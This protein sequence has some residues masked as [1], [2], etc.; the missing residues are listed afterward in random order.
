MDFDLDAYLAPFDPEVMRYPEGRKA[1]TRMEPLA[2]ALTYL[3]PHLRDE[4]TG[5][6]TLSEFHLDLVQHA[7]GWVAPEREPRQHRDCFVAPRNAGKSSWCF[8]LLPLWAAC[9]GHKEFIAAI[10][11]SATQSEMHLATLRR[12][13]ETNTLLR[14]DFPEV[15][16]PARKSR[17]TAES[18]NVAM[19]RAASGFTI[20]A[21]G[22]DSRILGMKVGNKRPDL[23]LMDDV[24][25]PEEN[26]SIALKDKRL[27]AIQDSILPLNERARVV[28]VGTVT[29]PDSIIHD[30]VKS[31][32]MPAEAPE[33]IA[34]Q[35]FKT[36][37]YPALITDEVTGEERSV[38]PAKWSLEYLR[39]IRHTRDFAKNFMNDPRGSGGAWWRPEDFTYGEVRGL[40]RQVLSIDPA[41]TASGKSD[42]TALSVVAYSPVE[43]KCVVLDAWQLRIQPGKALRDRVL[44]ILEEYLDT[45]GV[46]VESNQGGQVWRSILHDISVPIT[47]IHQSVAKEVRAANL[48]N[49]YQLGKVVHAKALTAA[50]NQ[51]IAFPKAPHDDLI[52]SIGAGVFALLPKPKKRGSGVHSVAVR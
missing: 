40:A 15:C 13:L 32:T 21:R 42:Y 35:N 33:W 22:A 44:A 30:L 12:E 46:L 45:A 18:D 8:L 5:Q 51:M 17:G 19:Y 23:I 2:F 50:E 16:T 37:Y 49:K 31:V 26:Y 34:A 39:S 25:P 10:A 41:V 24:E 48:L 14:K 7:I 52:D 38:W 20:I 4:A 3:E 9:H 1:V 29:M 27:G 47:T 36:H 11:D 6:V 28:L 43:D